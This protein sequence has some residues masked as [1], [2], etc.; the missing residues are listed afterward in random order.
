MVS[1]LSPVILRVFRELLV[2]VT[3][4]AEPDETKF[5]VSIPAD[6][7]SER[8]VFDVPA[9]DRVIVCASAAPLVTPDA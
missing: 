3:L 4:L 5:T 6:V 1:A 2:N 8:A 9:P 7:I